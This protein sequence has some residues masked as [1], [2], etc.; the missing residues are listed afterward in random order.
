MVSFKILRIGVLLLISLCLYGCGED[1]GQERPQYSGPVN[2]IIYSDVSSN[3]LKAITREKAYPSAND[4]TSDQDVWV[5]L[6]SNRAV[7]TLRRNHDHSSTIARSY[8]NDYTIIIPFQ[9]IQEIVVGSSEQNR[10]IVRIRK[11][12]R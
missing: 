1:S 2:T 3:R 10:E 7:V 12:Q 9:H 4:V 6:F 8:N 5:D 11:E